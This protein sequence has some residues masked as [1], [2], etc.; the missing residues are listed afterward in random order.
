MGTTE[1]DLG[2]GGGVV[3]KLMEDCNM[4]PIPR[5]CWVLWFFYT[6]R[7]RGETTVPSTGPFPET[8]HHCT[9]GP[10]SGFELE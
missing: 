6:L 8:L 5:S 7:T 9:N 1:L 2:G 3:R 10:E 4:G